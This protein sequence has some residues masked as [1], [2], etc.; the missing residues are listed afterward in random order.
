MDRI[1]VFVGLDYHKES[2]RVCVE[3][4]QGR[5]L[6]NRGC[7]N[8]ARRVLTYAESFG[9][10]Q[11]AAIESCEGTADFAEELIDKGGWKVHLAHPGYV[12]RLRQNPDKTDHSDARLLAD[13][14]RVGYVPRVW[15]APQSVRE[16][17]RLVRYRRQLVNERRAIKLRIRS[18]MREHRRP[19]EAP[20]GGRP[21]SPG[22]ETSRCPI[23]HVGFSIGTWVGWNS[24]T[25]T[26][27]KW[28]SIWNQ[29][30]RTISWCSSYSCVKGWV[31]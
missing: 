28:K 26:S 13:L 3:D 1:P 10:V 4:A 19:C 21:G 17:R 23:H 31:R 5:V 9:C 25:P 16:L 2:I 15:L 27:S 6:G 30:P 8:D 22:C 12:R 11:G 29:R 24:S 7:S 14:E 18:L 20:P